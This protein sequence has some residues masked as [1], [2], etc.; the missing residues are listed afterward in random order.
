MRRKGYLVENQQAG[1]GKVKRLDRK[2]PADEGED[3]EGNRDQRHE[4]KKPPAKNLCWNKG[5]YGNG[6]GGEGS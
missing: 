5:Q 2:P 1:S 3:I 6:P 4:E